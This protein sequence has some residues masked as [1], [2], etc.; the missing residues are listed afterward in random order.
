MFKPL[1]A[2]ISSIGYTDVP[3]ELVYPSASCCETHEMSA[4]IMNDGEKGK[5]ADGALSPAL[6]ASARTSATAS[7][8]GG[9]LWSGG[10]LESWGGATASLASTRGGGPAASGVP[11][12]L[13]PDVPQ[14]AD[15]KPSSPASR[16]CPE[17][18]TTLHLRANEEAILIRTPGCISTT[19]CGKIG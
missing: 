16:A 12:A 15:S 17:G 2:L 9:A 4:P 6:S 8:A 14:A 11:L 3:S 13:P 5:G 18:T 7:F 1:F 19:G 10:G